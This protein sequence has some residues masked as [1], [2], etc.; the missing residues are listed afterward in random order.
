MSLVS[1][2]S[3]RWLFIWGRRFSQE[4]AAT[5]VSLDRRPPVLLLRAFSSDGAVADRRWLRQRSFATWFLGRSSFE[6]RIA[7]VMENLGP[8]VALGR[9]S[10]ILPTYGFARHYVRDSE[11]RRVFESYV[12]TAGWAVIL[13]YQIT[14]NLMYEIKTVLAGGHGL[15]I[16]LVPPPSHARTRIWEESVDRMCAEIG[17]TLSLRADVAALLLEKNQPMLPIAMTG[18]SS[19]ESQ[20]A[21]IEGT[22]IPQYLPEDSVQVSGQ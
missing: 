16:L 8:T 3:G 7:S 18:G 12:G 14:P 11:W 9:R 1:A 13:L 15:K 20:I 19:A 4:S 6:E 10:E 17:V 2:I 5:R 22:L 21:A